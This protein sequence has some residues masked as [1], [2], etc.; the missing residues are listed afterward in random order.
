VETEMMVEAQALLVKVIM[1]VMA[2]LTVAVAV[3]VK[4]QLAVMRLQIVQAVLV[5]VVLL[6][7]MEVPMVVAVV[8]QAQVLVEHQAGQAVA[9]TVKQAVRQLRAEP[10]QAEAVAAELKAIMPH[11]AVQEL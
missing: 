9:V 11:Q 8:A 1:V 2:Q 5:E 7:L 6:G 4:M 10:I 3:E